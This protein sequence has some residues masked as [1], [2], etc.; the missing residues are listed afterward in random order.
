MSSPLPISRPSLSGQQASRDANSLESSKEVG[1]QAE[2]LRQQ[3]EH[4]VETL[5]YRAQVLQEWRDAERAG[6]EQVARM[7]VG[8]LGPRPS[9]YAREYD[10][11]ETSYERV[12]SAGFL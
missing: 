10:A 12:S 6:R 2:P 11:F 7:A 9:R 1:L 8:E 3:Y 5:R 4:A